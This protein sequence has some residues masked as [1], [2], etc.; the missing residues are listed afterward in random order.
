MA[1]A[2]IARSTILP[3]HIIARSNDL[4]W[5]GV[6]AEQAWKIF[7]DQLWLTHLRYGIEIYAFVLMKRHFHLLMSTPEGNASEALQYFLRETA[8]QLNKKVG[9][10]KQIFGK[11][12]SWGILGSADHYINALKYIYLTPVREGLTLTAQSYIYSTLFFLCGGN[13]S[14][15]PLSSYPKRMFYQPWFNKPDRLANFVNSGFQFKAYTPDRGRIS[16]QILR[17]NQNLPKSKVH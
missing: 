11:K 6:S 5:Y 1:K 4:D 15:I 3:Y 10:Q 17:S 8:F 14:Q 13:R 12:Y 7:N 2:K 16:T 9:T